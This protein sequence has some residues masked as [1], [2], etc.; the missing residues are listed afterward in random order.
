MNKS[1]I[2]YIHVKELPVY[3]TI[4]LAALWMSDKKNKV[5]KHVII[6]ANIWFFEWMFNLSTHKNG[7]NHYDKM[8]KYIVVHWLLPGYVQI[9]IGDT[10]GIR[11][12][13]KALGKLIWRWMYIPC[14]KICS[15][16][17][18]FAI[19]SSH[20]ESVCP[21]FVRLRIRDPFVKDSRIKF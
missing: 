7:H 5:L 18:Q 17:I 11:G 9:C 12:S 4:F 3:I 10:N 16:L 14:S 1:Q 19:I 2:N 20:P 8:N 21:K 15:P 6:W 13:G